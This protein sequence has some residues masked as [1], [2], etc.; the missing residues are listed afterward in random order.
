MSDRQES[1]VAL[2]KAG[3]PKHDHPVLRRVFKVTLA[4]GLGTYFVASGAFLGLRYV[5]LPRIDDFRPRIEQFVSAKLHAQ[6]SIGK[7][8][9]HWSGMQPGVEVTQ[10]TIRGRDGQVALS[11]P[12]AT[13][14]LSWMSL[15]RLSPALSSLIVD[16]PDLIVERSAD[17]ALFIAG[18]GVPTTHGGN[19][20]FSTWLLKQEAIV[21]RGG[22]LRWRDAKHDAP[23]LAL[24]GIRLAVL[25]DGRVHKAALQAPANGTLLRGP[26]DFRARFTHKALAPI[27]KPANWTGDAYLSTGPV[28]LPT[29]ARYVNMPFTIHAGQIDNAIW[30]TFRDGRLRAAGGDLRGADVALRVRPTQP[31]LDVPIARFGWDMTMDTGHDYTLHLSHFHAELGQPPLPDGTPLGRALG[32]ATLTARYRVPTASQ[33]Q[34][35]SVAGDRAD[36]GILS[37]FIRGLPLPAHLRNEL[38][39]VDPRGMVANYQ[40]EVERAKPARAELAD[41]EKRTG[42]APIVRY[43]FLGDLQ[44]ISFAA[45][46]PPPGLS[47]HGHPRAGWPGIENL[48][49]HVDANE[50]GGTAHFD[51]VNAA[52]TVPGVFDVPRLTFDRLKGNAK[53]AITPEPGDRH[54]RVDVTLP[55]LLVANPDAEIAVSGS[56]SNPG[57]GRGSLDLRADFARAAVARIPR[58][59]P[60][61]MSEHLRQYLGHALQAGQVTKGASIVARGP[62]EG[63][64]YSHDPSAG[65]FHIVAPFTG[66]QFEPTPFPPHKLA[67]GTPSVWPAL[68]GIDGVFELEQNKLRFDIDRA[69]YKRVAVTK[70]SGRIADLGHPAASPFV[71]EGHAQGPLADLIDYADN[72]S[73]GILS[74]HIGQKIDAQGPA[75]LAL[76]LTI[77]QH[78]P[79]PHTH[80]EGALAFGGNTL[81]TGGVP[82]LSALRGSVRFTEG[83]ASLD[84]L[85]GQFLGGPVRASGE[86]KS[87]GPYAV[88]VDGKLA[89]DAARGL[90]L[91]GPA[92]ALLEHVV[93][94]APYRIAVRG[95]PGSL[96]NITASSD[97]TGVALNFPAPFAKPAGTPMPFSFTLQPAAQ[98][99]GRRLE[100]ADLTL[101]PVT[102]TYLLD[103]TRGQPLRAVRGAMGIHRMPDVPQDGV[104][105]A[106]DVDELDADAWIAL[107][108]TLHPAQRAPEPQPGAER[109]DLASFV[110]KRFAFHF[111]TLKLLKRNWENVIVGASHV[112]ELWQANI[113]SN[114]VSGYLSWEPGGGHN[115]AGVLNA[116]LAKFVIPQSAEHD[117]VGRAM[118]LPTP[119]DRPMPSIDLVVDEVVARGHDIGRLVVNARNIE[120]GGTP[121]WQLDKLEL[122]N[123]A[124]RLTATGNWRTSRHALARG[125]DE[126]DAPRRSVFDFK[127]DIDNAGALLDRVGLP[128]TIADGHGTLTGKIGWR[129]GPTALDYPSLN[130]QLALDL[131]HGQIL[132][133]DPGAAKLLG[134][135]SLQSLARFLTLNFRDVVGKG[136]P[137]EKITGTGRITNGIARTDDFEMTTPPAKVTLK[138]SVDLG[139]ETQDLH[140]HVAPKVG[141]GTAAIAAA[142]INPLLGV[143]VLAA[144]YALSETLSHAFA[145]DYTINGSWAHPHIERVRGDQ[146]KMNHDAAGATSR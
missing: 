91:H 31:K 116:R 124:A 77:P 78:V 58:Y 72:S 126:A 33:G 103:A 64:P 108:R 122:S 17:G 13:A 67:N 56:Y 114:Q 18:V 6:L 139:A 32:L 131:E 14:A 47:A 71:I 129:G 142:I 123:P 95:A 111:G 92:A 50:T 81:S 134:V 138:G 117:L 99:D 28:D 130:G 82:P 54:A 98:A 65:V 76:K 45:Q 93:G 57:H 60:T 89:L 115:G 52:V 88:D 55:D 125:V 27:G 73:L 5:F 30:A 66:G 94:D 38:V 100:H 121:V 20:T 59:L 40:I 133:V 3:P 25:N 141:A 49:G 120:E 110:P 7:L 36:L 46:E 90:K 48:W 86:L 39:R 118:N 34:L 4:V 11:V 101:G 104:S 8:S 29:L 69:H 102:A 75:S 84:R 26:L 128:R 16:Q 112:D 42:T 107:A 23:E 12:H 74:G 144:N 21:L 1:A 80:V 135:L 70:V 127:L 87:H 106:V 35:I 51:T 137:F 146:G 132:K 83:G 63:F 85:S 143:G 24:S 62:L 68:A 37:E 96:P 2:P 105:A 19:D 145:I 140:A 97:L 61:G 10:L 43:R 15:L 109:V 22:T 119:T 9:P 113:A 136:L 44:G 79:H 41:E 53:W